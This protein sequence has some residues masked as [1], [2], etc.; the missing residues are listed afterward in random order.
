MISIARPG[1]IL[2]HEVFSA[3]QLLE[4]ECRRVR[5]NSL[6]DLEWTACNTYLHIGKGKVAN[7]LVQQFLIVEELSLEPLASFW[8]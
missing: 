8:A 1:F 3:R 2:S 4:A 6:L 7:W 5:I